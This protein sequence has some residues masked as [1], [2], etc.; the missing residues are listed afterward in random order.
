MGWYYAQALAYVQTETAQGVYDHVTHVGDYAYDLQDQ[1][2]NVGDQ[3]QASIEPITSGTPYMG[4]E[5]N[6]GESL[7]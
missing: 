3:F 7:K 4:C 2:G 1:N 5:G 6:H